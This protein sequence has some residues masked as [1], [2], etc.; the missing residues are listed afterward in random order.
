[1]L[2]D[3]TGPDAVAQADALQPGEIGLLADGSMVIK[4]ATG[5]LVKAG[6]KRQ[7]PHVRIG[8]MVYAPDT[9]P[10]VASLDSPSHHGLRPAHYEQHV[11]IP[12]DGTPPVLTRVGP[13]GRL[14]PPN[15]G[16]LFRQR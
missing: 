13:E 1:M 10:E 3:L 8:S 14:V 2:Y 6:E 4:S 12:A 16:L 15:F 7:A 9:T 11:D 5:L